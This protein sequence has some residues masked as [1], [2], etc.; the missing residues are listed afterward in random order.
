V[1]LISAFIV[2]LFV[3]AQPSHADELQSYGTGEVTPSVLREGDHVE[4]TYR[5]IDPRSRS[6]M[7]EAVG[8]VVEVAQDVFIV[9]NTDGDAVIEY[10]NVIRLDR[11]RSDAWTLDASDLQMP[12]AALIEK[13]LEGRELSGLEGTWVW[14]DASYEIVIIGN[15]AERIPRYDYVG[16]VLAS[17]V[18]D[19]QAGEVKVLLKETASEGTYSAIFVTDEKSRHGTTVRV[20]EGK[21]MEASFPHPYRRR[22]ITRLIH[23]T[24]PIP[25]PVDATT[26]DIEEKRAL[27]VGSGFFVTPT[28]VATANHLVEGS[29]SIVVK[30]NG[31]TTGAVIR[32]RDK[33]NDI[34][35]LTVE[36]ASLGGSPIIP[37]AVGDPADTLEGD[38]LVASGYASPTAPRPSVALLVVNSLFGTDDDLTQFTLSTSLG[39][40]AIGGPVIDTSN[41]VVG[42]ALPADTSSTEATH[43]A[44]KANLL[45]DLLKLSSLDSAPAPEPSPDGLDATLLGQMARSAVVLIESH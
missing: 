44:M 41:R 39:K 28:V 31:N 40:V 1:F 18:E 34:A 25:E 16:I 42:I 23:K 32:T 35:L 7:A 9:E 27:M 26:T 24:Y 4:V 13:Y 17:Q 12:Q 37:L 38:R 29:D 6:R 14:D 30:F 20:D 3:S 10:G 22:S 11:T 33:R 2:A 43:V 8:L 45:A 15:K 5:T 19:W 21:V 36:A